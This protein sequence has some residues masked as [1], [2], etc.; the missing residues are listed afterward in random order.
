MR[1]SGVS[2][3]SPTPDLFLAFGDVTDA[4]IL[5]LWKGQLGANRFYRP[6]KWTWARSVGRFIM[7]DIRGSGAY[8]LMQHYTVEAKSLNF[9]PLAFIL[10]FTL[11]FVSTRARGY[12]VIMTTTTLLFGIGRYHSRAHVRRRNDD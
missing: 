3:A 8:T 9:F 1:V 6:T 2:R 11:L 7:I 12:T 4:E 10:Y 5:C